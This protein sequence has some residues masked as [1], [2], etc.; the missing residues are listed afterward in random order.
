VLSD[1]TAAIEHAADYSL[2]TQSNPAVAGETI[3]VYMTGLGPVSSPVASGMPAPAAN[4][5]DCGQDAIPS[6]GQV[7]YAGL[8]PGTVG[9]YQLNLQLPDNLP[10]GSFQL[11]IGWTDCEFGN[12]IT[13]TSNTVTVPVASSQP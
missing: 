3:V 4:A 7:L 13:S 9:V 10:S 1:G 6:V 12:G 8:T 2:V 11:S 5:A